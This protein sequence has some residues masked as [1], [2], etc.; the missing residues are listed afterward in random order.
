MCYKSSVA[1]PLKSF[2][3]EAG[4]VQQFCELEIRNDDLVFLITRWTSQREIHHRRQ[5]FIE[6]PQT[7]D[8]KSAPEY[9]QRFPV[10]L[11]WKRTRHCFG[12]VDFRRNFQL[13]FLCFFR[14]QKRG[15]NQRP[16][17]EI[18]LEQFGR[19]FPDPG[20]FLYRIVHHGVEHF[21]DFGQ[22]VELEKYLQQSYCGMFPRAGP[23]PGF[24]V[25]FFLFHHFNYPLLSIILFNAAKNSEIL[26]WRSF[27]K[28]F[29]YWAC[30]RRPAFWQTITGCTNNNH[31]AA[32][33]R[34]CTF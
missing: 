4:G 34:P 16:Q 28:I 14:D 26:I 22:V 5:K 33:C 6:I 25:C 2:R 19:I 7:A 24:E 18:Q 10:F 17:R 1:F 21:F 20:F 32:V 13:S 9:P 12:K 8:F 11:F 23:E 30:R 3:D 31:L 27:K 15:P 29:A